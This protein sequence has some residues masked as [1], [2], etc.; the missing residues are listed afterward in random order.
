M[1]ILEI[2]DKNSNLRCHGKNIFRTMDNFLGKYPLEYRILYDKNIETL[3]IFKCDTFDR[4]ISNGY[5][6]ADDNIILYSD[7]IS[8]G[9]ELFHL[10]SNDRDNGISSIESGMGYEHGIDEGMT[11]YLLMLAYG[12]TRPDCYEFQVF[13]IRMLE[14]IPD[15][16]KYYFI[17]NHKE[18]IKLFPNRKDIYNLIF[19]LDIYHEKNND[20]LEY[21]CSN[22]EDDIKNSL[23]DINLAR[24]SIKEV[25][26]NLISIELS[27]EKS[28]VELK[29]YSDKFMDLIGSKDVAL[30]LKVFYPEYYEY[31]NTQIKTRILKR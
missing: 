13:A 7:D 4:K 26:N 9:H 30:M 20:Y 31:A 23:I 10:A 24:K 2:Y 25:I 28:S 15:L 11:E 12:L 6:D 16:F 1:Q 5:Y 19:S 29:R 18:F 21:L 17:P 3:Q 14:N 8:L 22:D 27:F